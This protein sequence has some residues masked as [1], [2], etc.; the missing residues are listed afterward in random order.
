MGFVI[1]AR[2]HQSGNITFGTYLIDLYALGVK[3]TSW[4][5]NVDW[6]VIESILF[7]GNFIEIAYDL[8]HN[9]IFGALEF[10]ADHGYKPHRDYEKYSKFILEIDDEKIPLI[11]V[12]FGKNG[13][14][15][16]VKGPF[17]H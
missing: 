3:D 14:M 17:D 10:A 7:Q 11:D 9:I 4:Y 1:V 8:A 12:A 13:K 5:F 6:S 15:F 16:L 2:I